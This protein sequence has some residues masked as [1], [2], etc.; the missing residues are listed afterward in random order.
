[1]VGGDGG[2]DHLAGCFTSCFKGFVLSPSP[3]PSLRGQTEGNEG[4]RTFGRGTR[5]SHLNSLYGRGAAVSRPGICPYPSGSPHVPPCAA[6]LAPAW[7][8]TQAVTHSWRDG[9][10]PIYL[11]SPG[12]RAQPSHSPGCPGVES[13]DAL[14]WD[15]RLHGLWESKEGLTDAVLGKVSSS[16]VTLHK[17]RKEAVA[18]F[19]QPGPSMLGAGLHEQWV[20][21]QSSRGGP[22]VPVSSPSGPS[23][24][25]VSDLMT[26]LWDE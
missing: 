13:G 3:C 22:T 21:G 11:R 24:E 2:R 10:S 15:T 20:E 6:L 18:S 23:G 16:W 7:L 14:P 5:G 17:S 26:R 4:M 19:R 1:M 25:V 8:M 12:H 9:P